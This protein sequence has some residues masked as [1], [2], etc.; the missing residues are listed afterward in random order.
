MPRLRLCRKRGIHLLIHH[1]RMSSEAFRGQS[2]TNRRLSPPINAPLIQRIDDD[3]PGMSNKGAHLRGTMQRAIPGF[4]FLRL[5]AMNVYSHP[6]L[7]PMLLPCPCRNTAPPV[8]S[9]D[10]GICRSESDRRPGRFRAEIGRTAFWHSWQPYQRCP[11]RLCDS[12]RAAPIPHQR[13]E[14]SKPLLSQHGADMDAAALNSAR[15]ALRRRSSVLT[16]TLCT[17]ASEGRGC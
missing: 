14:Y 10:G 17:L 13:M 12:D 15:A 3:Y 16:R 4:D 7:H 1:R 6:T 2:G 11:T 8:R 9:E 5:C